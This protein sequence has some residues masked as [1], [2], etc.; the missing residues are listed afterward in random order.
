MSSRTEEFSSQGVAAHDVAR[1][2][3]GFLCATAKSLRPDQ[4]RTRQSRVAI[5]GRAI[6]CVFPLSRVT[7]SESGRNRFIFVEVVMLYVAI[8]VLLLLVLAG[9]G[10]YV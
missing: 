4:P 10:L 8:G 5:M 1:I 2:F 9:A 7:R 3:L 6:F